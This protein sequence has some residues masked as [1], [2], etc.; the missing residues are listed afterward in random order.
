MNQRNKQRERRQR[1]EDFQAEMRRSWHLVPNTW[2]MRIADGG[3]GTRPADEIILAPE[4]NILAE[5]KRT[6]GDRFELSF[7]R[8]NQVRGLLD[9][10]GVI[11]RNYGLVFISFHNP[12]KDLDECYALRLVE[13]LRYM[14]YKERQHIL[15]E[16]LQTLKT[17]RSHPV[18]IYVPRLHEDTY[19]L[20]RVAECYRYL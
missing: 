20:G 18:G 17:E 7:L 4:V 12:E 8:P 16:E 10:D 14:Q 1:G 6:S 5:H 11:E 9:F 2:R 15:L 19:D 3:G 13:T